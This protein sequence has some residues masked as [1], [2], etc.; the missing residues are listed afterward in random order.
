MIDGDLRTLHIRCGSDIRDTL[1]GAGFGGD[2]LEYA[3]PVCEGPV[4][5]VPDLPPVRARYLAAGV[6]GILGFTEAACLARLREAEQRLA[7]AH[8]YERVV[9]WFEHDSHD[10]LLLARCLA[11]FAATTVPAC[12][13]LICID[14]HPSVP[15]FNG[16]GQLDAAALAGLW[17]L[18]QA[19][20]ADQI[21]LGQSVWDALRQPD[22]ASLQA[23]AATGTPALPITAR[24]LWRHLQELPGVADGLSL[25]QRIV[26][27]LLA[28]KPMR[29]GRVF[30][31]MVNGREPLVF[32][33][34]LGVLG[35]IE[36]MADAG[37]ISIEPGERPFP[38]LA[39]ITDP[40]RRVMAGQADYLAR[41]PAERWV[42][43]VVCDGRWRWDGAAG[44]V[45]PA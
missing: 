16:L 31:A 18:R 25:T 28:E 7:D 20:T 1:T 30:E 4:P 15:R 29:I 44:S 35:T 3:D 8:H 22:P 36:R 13:E 2:F 17:P 32:M 9:L 14:T 5:D 33:A 26:L 19:V 10:Q 23:I 27:G 45:R 37:V 43:G 42:G 40:G 24:A 39:A 6:G 12:L 41:Q 11:R 21:V 38:R 34:D